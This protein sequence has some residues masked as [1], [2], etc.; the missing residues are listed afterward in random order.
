MV[1]TLAGQSMSMEA[2]L[3]RLKTHI[4]MPGTTMG[5]VPAGETVTA[6]H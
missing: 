3:L 5:A 2:L 6:D 4:P 1:Q